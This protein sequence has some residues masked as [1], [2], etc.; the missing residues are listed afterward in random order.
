MTF[1]LE[2]KLVVEN[3]FMVG[4]ESV[5]EVTETGTRLISTVPVDIFILGG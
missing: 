3:E 5:F 1:A 2:P 4:V